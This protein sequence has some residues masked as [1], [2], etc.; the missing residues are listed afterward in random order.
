MK[1]LY[2]RFYDKTWVSQEFK[3]K[4]NKDSSANALCYYTFQKISDPLN[5]FTI[6]SHVDYSSAAKYLKEIRDL[7][8]NAMEKRMDTDLKRYFGGLPNDDKT[9]VCT[10]LRSFDEVI[11]V[12]R[13]DISMIYP[14]IYSTQ[15]KLQLLPSETI[16]YLCYFENVHGYVKSA[17]EDT[18]VKSELFF[19][20]LYSSPNPVRT[21]I[22]INP[23]KKE[24]LR[25]ESRQPD[26]KPEI[27]PETTR[28]MVTKKRAVKQKQPDKKI[29]IKPETKRPKPEIEQTN[30]TNTSLNQ[31]GF[32]FSTTAPHGYTGF[33]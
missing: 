7:D 28:K 22:L 15:A 4:L 20:L 18:T 5:I 8:M 10:Y 14:L 26:K 2:P 23:Q 16:T 12:D 6:D 25:R 32:N 24:S 33:K 19:T 27:K 31:P 17:L 29:E 30:G 1:Y 21:N 9:I 11:K 13:Y 3:I